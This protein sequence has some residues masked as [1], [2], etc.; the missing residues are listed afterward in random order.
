MTK[1]QL[2]YW[3]LRWTQYYEKRYL[4]I[5]K[6][7][8]NEEERANRAR[9]KE[10]VRHNKAQERIQTQQNILTKQKLDQDW[11]KMSVEIKSMYVHDVVSTAKTLAE[12]D[13]LMSKVK[14]AEVETLL[15]IAQANDKAS[16][17]YAKAAVDAYDKAWG[18]ELQ[19]GGNKTSHFNMEVTGAAAVVAELFNNAAKSGLA[20]TRIRENI[21]KVWPE[22]V[23][24][25]GPSADKYVTNKLNKTVDDIKSDYLTQE[26]EKRYGITKGGNNGSSKTTNDSNYSWSKS[27][28]DYVDEAKKIVG[29]SYDKLKS[30]N[31]YDKSANVS[32]P[33]GTTVINGAVYRPSNQGGPGVSN[34]SAS[35]TSSGTKIVYSPGVSSNRNSGPGVNRR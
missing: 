20:A 31:P 27:S 32:T 25:L 24:L 16:I 8:A 19:L 28:A 4:E 30:A 29:P 34:S 15:S 11:A 1:N 12:V 22:Y 23:E 26:A 10:N 17:D 7:K 14:T 13:Q 35:S 2:E 33:S 21:V 5:Q 6:Q 9:E 18:F 3:K